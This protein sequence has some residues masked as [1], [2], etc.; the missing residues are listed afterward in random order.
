MG[1][2]GG[3]GGV[4]VVRVVGWRSCIVMEEEEPLTPALSPGY[5]GEGVER[6]AVRRLNEIAATTPD[7]FYPPRGGTAGKPAR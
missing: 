7:A 6:C 4:S 2:C 5:R 1:G 3:A